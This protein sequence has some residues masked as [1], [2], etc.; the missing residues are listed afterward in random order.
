[1][2]KLWIWR[3]CMDSM[4]VGNV[5]VG[6]VLVSA[7]CVRKVWLVIPFDH[8]LNRRPVY[9]PRTLFF[10]S[11]D[12]FVLLAFLEEVRHIQECVALQAEVYESRLHARKN[13]GYAAFMNAA[14]E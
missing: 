11:G 13:T 7:A 12:P 1:M 6:K 3:L 9:T 8:G 10:A 2:R 4:G 5:W 14:R